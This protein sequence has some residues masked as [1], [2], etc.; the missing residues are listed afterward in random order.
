MNATLID[1]GVAEIGGAVALG[2]APRVLAHAQPC[3]RPIICV[4]GARPNYMKMAPIIRAL[5]ASWPATPPLL[6]HTGQHYDAAM[7]DSF[8]TA[9]GMPRPTVNLEV[10]SASHA[11]QTAEIMKRFEPVLDAHDAAAVLVVGDVNSTIACALVAGKKGVP[12]AHVEAGLRSY[13]RTMPEE[14]N[15]VLTDQIADLLYTTERSA[16]ANLGREG[17]ADERIVFVGNVMIDTLLANRAHAVPAI[18]T[19]RGMPVAD[20]IFRSAKEGA[21][22]GGAPYARYG[23]V[24]L[25]RPSNVDDRA[26]FVRLLGALQAISERLPLVLALHPRTQARITEFGFNDFFDARRVAILPPQGYLE[27]LGLMADATVVLTDSGGLQEETTALGVPCLTLR[28]N[29]ERP[30]TIAEGTNTLCGT[31]ARRIIDGV[32]DVLATG[33]KRGRAPELWDGHAAERIARHL[34]AWLL[35][36]HLQK[37][38]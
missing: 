12:V 6:V 15:R 16:H 13:D 8:F 38:A 3:T 19:L 26:T 28:H 21:S 25:H 2:R 7:N 37:A 5:A 14:I 9:L 35:A 36:R 33:G 17:I 31:D 1:A 22:L 30:I 20:A 29:T 34:G 32:A 4:V 11:V 27:M 24:T 23:V 10:G 18:E